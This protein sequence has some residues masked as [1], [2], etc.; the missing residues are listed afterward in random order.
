[1]SGLATAFFWFAYQPDS[2]FSVQPEGD[3]ASATY[4]R[5]F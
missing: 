1:V 3:G 5:T 2:S 4:L